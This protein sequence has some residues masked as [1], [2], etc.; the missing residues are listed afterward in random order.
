MDFQQESG[1]P[2]KIRPQPAAHVE[3]DEIGRECLQV[4]EEG[5]HKAT[6]KIKLL[7]KTAPFQ[8]SLFLQA[9]PGENREYLC[10][11]SFP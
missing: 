1:I 9:T 11:Q 4:Y 3:E 10:P 6:E 8:L 7:T 5:I 2:D